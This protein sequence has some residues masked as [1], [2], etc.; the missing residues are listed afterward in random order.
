MTHNNL[1]PT[2][3]IPV[4]LAQAVS[5]SQVSGYK[6][7]IAIDG[8]PFNLDP[9]QENPW[10]WEVRED[11]REQF[12]NSS[13]MGEQTFGFWWLRSQSS[14]HGG[15]GQEWL[16]SGTEDPA[17]ARI[18]YA[19][20]VSMDVF[21]I[22]GQITPRGVATNTAIT[23][24]ARAV[25]FTR[26]GLNKIAIAKGN[27]DSLDFYNVSPTL[28]FDANVALAEGGAACLDITTDGERL[29]VAINNKIIRIDE[30]GVQTDI[31]T[32]AF[33]KSVRIAYV[34]K[35]L[36]LAHGKDVYEVDPDPSVPPVALVYGTHGIFQ[37]KTPGW[38]FTD[39]AEGPNG[40]YLTGHAGLTGQVWQITEQESGATI[41]LGGGTLQI[42]LPT[43][44]IPYA[45]FFYVN[46]L[47]V[48]GTSAGAR[49][50][51]FSPDGR[52]Q[53]GP[54]SYELSPVRCVGAS[55]RA[56]FLGAD[57]GVYQLDLGQLVTRS[58]SYAYAHRHNATT[59]SPYRSIVTTGAV[60]DVDVYAVHSTGIEAESADSSGS[61]LT[62]WMTWSTTEQ[63]RVYSVVMQGRLTTGTAT[64]TVENFEGDTVAYAIGAD[65]TRTI[66]EFGVDLDPSTAYRVSVSFDSGTDVNYLASLQLKALP[67][68]RR[69]ETI[70]L[71]LMMQNHEQTSGGNV[72]GYDNFAL[73]RV[74]ALVS[75]ARTN[76]T[77]TVENH[78]TNE[79]YRAQIR[80]LQFRQVDGIA[81]A[82]GRR[83]GGVANVV[84]R[85]VT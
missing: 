42:T 72:I 58:G 66:W 27:T 33:T 22:P 54:L 44:E 30:A 40:I 68:E 57:D 10:V 45:I 77:I 13:E 15:A 50:G 62:S 73:D 53:F 24:V 26:G 80:D 82:P 55:G 20:S 41:S 52:P 29:F 74:K 76:A 71:P 18:R 51:S 75:V 3:S 8:I 35:R 11:R 2:G 17:L 63:K 49:V 60:G 39:I 4:D 14:F 34:K 25:A 43:G 64:L 85:V 37:V 56:V 7:D 1:I 19:S 23:S 31:A 78:V 69:Y 21:S 67:Q 16:D 5:Q 9:T 83:V 61:L 65:A 32:L 70:A 46:S 12:D 48:L 59:A 47:F 81:P 36:I 84:L 6:L 28:A 79:S 38:T